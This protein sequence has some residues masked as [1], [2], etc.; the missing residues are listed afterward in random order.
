MENLGLIL[1]GIG[2]ARTIRPHWALAELKLEYESRAIQARSQEIYSSEYTSLNAR[3]KI[4]LLQHGNFTISE[5][6][7]IVIYLSDTFGNNETA[8]LPSGKQERAQCLEWCF[9]SLSELDATSLYVIRRHKYLPDIYG[10]A[11]EVCSAASKY[12]LRQLHSV[13][14]Q[15]EKGHPFLLSQHLT[16]ADI[17]LTSCLTWADRYEVP[18]PKIAVNYYERLT[19]LTS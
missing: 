6:A 17:L 4:P 1:W 16:A 18:I 11:P 5:S 14:R 9:F 8:L 3:Q 7:A 10:T 2:T 13:E 12:F 19:S 15:L